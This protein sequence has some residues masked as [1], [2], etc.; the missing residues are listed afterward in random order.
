MMQKS[1]K[2]IN[3][4][5]DQ[6]RDM[7]NLQKLSNPN[8]TSKQY[9]GSKS[10]RIMRVFRGYGE[11]DRHTKVWTTKGLKDRRIRLSEPAA[12]ILYHL[13]DRLGLSQPSKVTD[14]LLD[15]TK[16]DVDKLPVPPLQMALEDFNPFHFPSTF[17]HQ[18]FNS[19]PL[20]NELEPSSNISLSRFSHHLDHTYDYEPQILSSF[21]GT[22]TPSLC[23]QYIMHDHSHLLSSS[24]LHV[25]VPHNLIDTQEKVLLGLNTNSKINDDG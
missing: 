23:P 3:N 17:V 11:K 14:W 9:S 13:Q 6:E 1:Y 20:A 21:S 7:I 22:G 5:Y 16:D 12:L 2:M 10:S 4:T 15:V 24:S 19:T 18:D 25:V 8:R